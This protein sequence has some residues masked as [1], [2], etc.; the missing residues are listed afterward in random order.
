[1]LSDLGTF[2]EAGICIRINY[3]TK[4]HII[5]EMHENSNSS[6]NVIQSIQR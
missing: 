2:K 3:I 6:W 5:A 4:E 1:M